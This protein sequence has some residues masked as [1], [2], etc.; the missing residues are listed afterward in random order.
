MYGIRCKE[1][2]KI[3]IGCTKRPL[4]ERFADH[5]GQLKRNEKTIREYGTPYAIQKRVLSPWQEDYNKYG[6][7]AFEL[8]LIEDNIPDNQHA[9]KEAYWIH[10]YK[11]NDK[12]YGY[13]I[14]VKKKSVVYPYAIQLPPKAFCSDCEVAQC[15]T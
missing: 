7:E 6:R 14:R 15:L 12:R 8:Y 2:G 5:F 3:Y 11:S 13:N 10:E 1:N 4:Q 9:E